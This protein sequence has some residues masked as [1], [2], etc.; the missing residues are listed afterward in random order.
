MSRIVYVNGRYLA[1]EE[2][3]ISVFDRGFLFADAVYEVTAVLD[4]RLVDYAG[5]VRRLE[6]SLAEL[7]MAMP[8]GGDELLD[9]HRRLVSRNGLTEGLVY[10]QVTR[11]VADRDFHYPAAT[12]QTLVM[13]TQAR[14]LVTEKPGMRVI[15][16]PD[17]RWKRRDIK[18]VQLLAAS[19][20]KMAAKE[21]GKDDAWL[22]DDGWVTEGT[23]SNAYIVTR[24]DT[25]VTRDLSPALLSGITRMA[26]LRLA[27]ETN[28][29]IAER[30]FTVREAQQAKEAFATSATAFVQPVVE[31]DG[32]TLADGQSGPVTR[33][34]HGLYLQECTKMLI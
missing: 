5:H 28:M 14:L 8:T 13:F 32:V 34:L 2:A 33:R 11:G 31:I 25:I 18:T 26:V 19:M 12:P 7:G 29:S 1:E 22:V 27:R 10:L 4:G 24:D 15:T 20:A 3:R 16:L 9:L 21:A 6:R 23:S 17:M 30:P